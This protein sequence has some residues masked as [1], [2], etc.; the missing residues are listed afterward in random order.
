MEKIPAIII[1]KITPGPPTETANA[2]PTT[3][4]MPAEAE[5]VAVRAW[6]D[7][8][9]PC[10]LRVI[11]SSCLYFFVIKFIACLKP[12][13]PIKRVLNVKYKAAH[14]NSTIKNSIRTP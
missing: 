4:P 13:N 11:I 5:I 1:Q 2:E 8:T 6:K 10:F 7:E 3:F 14:I 9:S 12:H